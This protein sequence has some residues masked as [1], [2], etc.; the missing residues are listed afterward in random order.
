[1][2]RRKVSTFEPMPPNT[3]GGLMNMMQ[4]V[5]KTKARRAAVKASVKQARE[6]NLDY[7]PHTVRSPRQRLSAR[8]VGACAIFLPIIAFI[9]LTGPRP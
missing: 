6:E 8:V 1:M 3:A 2:G 9:L 4:T 7:Y 5:P